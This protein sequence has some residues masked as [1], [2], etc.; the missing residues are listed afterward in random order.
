MIGLQSVSVSALGVRTLVLDQF[1]GLG[2]VDDH[3]YELPR[4][5]PY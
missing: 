1:I 4:C 2:A 3:T 5:F